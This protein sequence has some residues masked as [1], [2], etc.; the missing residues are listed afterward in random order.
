V[1]IVVCV[2]QIP[3]SS[4]VYIDPIAGKVD[5]ERFVRVLNPADACAIEAAVRLKEQLG[6]TIT[7]LTCG[8]EEAEGALRA[9]LAIGADRGVRLWNA[10]ARS[11]GW[12]PFIIAS[13]LYS[14][15]KQVMLPLDL[16]LCGVASNDWS[17]GIIGP[18]LAEML[19]L[20]QVTGVVELVVVQ[21]HGTDNPILQVTRKLDDGYRERLEAEPPLLITVTPD[22]NEPRYP[23][24]PAHI[25][26]LRATLPVIDP[27]PFMASSGEAQFEETALL[28]MH[29]P[30]PRPRHV[31][32]PD[33]H[34]SAFERISEIVS[35]GTT[36]HK[37]RLVD[38]SNEELAWV[39]V[40]FL[41]DKGFV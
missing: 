10:D 35:G 8:P 39:L 23:S 37:T 13:V 32:M 14:Y 9:A 29:V 15:I 24:L 19:A 25:A 33:S 28:E 38:G 22:L 18:A 16:V 20:P 17:S 27:L 4:S 3:D 21:A 12:G 1:N 30:R 2:K 41:R 26:A 40:E 11:E 34:H 6:G 31:S 5:E 7:A 36:G